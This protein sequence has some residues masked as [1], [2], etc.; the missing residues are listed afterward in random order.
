MNGARIGGVVVGILLVLSGGTFA[1][2]GEGMLPVTFMFQ[3]RTWVY[4]GSFLLLVGIVIILV[5]TLLFK[6]G[7]KVSPGSSVESTA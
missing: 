7:K 6:S 3:N 5:S 1:L 4:I 2:Q